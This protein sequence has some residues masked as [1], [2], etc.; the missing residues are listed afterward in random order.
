[1][2]EPAG[3]VRR[4]FAPADWAAGSTRGTFRPGPWSSGGDEM[5]PAPTGT[6][7]ISCCYPLA[8]LAC[9]G[10]GDANAGGLQA[11]RALG[12]LELHELVL[13]EATEAVAVDLGVM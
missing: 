10:S 7:P 9:R 6:G 12:H 4:R 3:D 1:M 11:L 13:L 2:T 5:G 8:G